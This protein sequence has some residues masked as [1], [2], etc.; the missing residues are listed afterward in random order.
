[1]LQALAEAMAAKGYAQTS[2]ADV[3]RIARVSRETFY[4]Q[5]AS[6]EDCFMSAFET[7]VEVLVAA[8][9][10]GLD[11][12]GAAST[13]ERFDRA[14]AAYL[15]A[16]ASNPGYARVFLIEVYAAGPSVLER[17][18]ELHRL[19]VDALAKRFAARSKQDRFKVEALVAAIV[20]MVTT[21]VAAGDADALRALHAPLVALA[22]ELLNPTKEAR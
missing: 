3:L 13:P 4:E 18:A 8:S 1:M 11:A 12:A 10:D 15:D 19:L 17:R 20:S 22:G 7:A 14:L 6:K 16:L 9:A 5:F 21:R 2:V